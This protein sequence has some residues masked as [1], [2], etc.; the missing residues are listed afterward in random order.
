MQ[1]SQ[2]TV[3]RIY[4]L[5]QSEATTSS[6]KN[7]TKFALPIGVAVAGVLSFGAVGMVLIK[8]FSKQP[9]VNTIYDYMR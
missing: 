9:A 3:E 2:T 5:P 1:L 4:V 6:E 8:Y 7:V